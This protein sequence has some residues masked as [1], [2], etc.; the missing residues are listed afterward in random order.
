MLLYFEH[1]L[2]WVDVERIRFF[3]FLVLFL[4]HSLFIILYVFSFKK[5][6]LLVG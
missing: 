5:E 3:V 6:N 2:I 4:F 1:L